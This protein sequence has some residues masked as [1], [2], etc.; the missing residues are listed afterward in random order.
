[1]SD[2][3]GPVHYQISITGRQAG[4]F[5]LALLL[6]LGLSFFFGMRTGSA[7]RKGPEPTAAGSNPAVPTLAPEDRKAGK[8]SVESSSSRPEDRKL[9]FDSSAAAET[10]KTPTPEPAATAKPAPTATR[11]P[12]ATAT[13]PP[14]PAKKEGPFWVQVLATKNASTADDMAK[15]LKGEGF[16]AD[17]SLVPGKAGWFR[18]RVGPFN[19]RARAEATAAKIQKTDKQIKKKPFVTP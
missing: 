2:D 3:R 14:A 19:D 8:P 5:F 15:R 11:E 7:A 18:V 12:K 9:G 1:L 10:K 4:V 17:V 6:A 13:K 16:S